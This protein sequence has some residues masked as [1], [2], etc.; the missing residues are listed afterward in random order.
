MSYGAGWNKE[1]D[2]RDLNGRVILIRRVFS[3]YLAGNIIDFEQ[4][5]RQ[6]RAEEEGPVDIRVRVRGVWGKDQEG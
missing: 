1:R 2:R 4:S 3:R 5:S 6:G